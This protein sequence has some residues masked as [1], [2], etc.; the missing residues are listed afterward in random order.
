MKIFWVNYYRKDE[1]NID[2]DEI[3]VPI[4]GSHLFNDKYILL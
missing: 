1:Q 2:G 3:Y 4:D